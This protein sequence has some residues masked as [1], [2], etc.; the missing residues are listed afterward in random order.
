VDKKDQGAPFASLYLQLFE[1]TNDAQYILDEEDDRFVKVNAAFERLTGYSKDD[2]ESGK[3]RSKDLLV[4]GDPDLSAEEGR[5]KLKETEPGCY[6]MRILTRQSEIKTLEFSARPLQTHDKNYTLGSVRD[7]TRRKILEQ[8]LH[9][10]VALQK[11]KTIEAA[12]AS[13][14]IYQLTEKI[15]NAPQ[16]TNALLNVESVDALLAESA[17]RL[18]DKGGLGYAAVD[19]LLIEGDN[20]I[21]RFASRKTSE[22]IYSLAKSRSRFARV[23]RG[24]EPVI[25]SSTGEILLPIRSHNNI[26]GVVAVLFDRTERTLFDDSET[27]RQGQEDIL[28]SIASSIG[29]MIDNLKLLAKV[30]RQSLV[31][32]LTNVFNRRFFDSKLK[33]EFQRA[34]RYRR[35]L[36]LIM[37]DLD[38]FKHVNDTYG[39][40]QGDRVL[41]DMSKVFTRHCRE[42]DLVF[43]YG[44]DEF[45]FLLPETDI[46]AALLLGERLRKITE[47]TPF[48]NIAVRGAEPLRLTLSV[49]VSAVDDD[50]DSE[51]AFLSRT[52]DA[53][54]ISKRNGR[55]QVRSLPGDENSIH[56]S[57]D[58]A[59]Q[60]LK[61]PSLGGEG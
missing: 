16:L 59:P 18:C 19:F 20:L 58:D 50:V 13:V 24:E 31:D 5:K 60:K 11:K 40:P 7:I 44:G 36:S 4:P 23:A 26:I 45:I 35:D 54:Y 53:L 46:K 41:V 38:F 39:H 61:S 32:K 47:E 52:D 28:K 8:R 30:K 33:E 6:E 17:R 55:N 10:E 14:R 34:K 22:A 15:R 57:P 42:S 3:I 9:T 2:L 12:K 29:L 37:L 48:P 25:R 21:R 49:G 51:A 27:V 1:Q 56:T 43:R